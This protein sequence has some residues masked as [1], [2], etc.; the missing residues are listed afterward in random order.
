MPNCVRRPERSCGWK[1]PP[2]NRRTAT[3]RPSSPGQREGRPGFRLHMVHRN[4][5]KRSWTAYRARKKPSRPQGAWWQGYGPHPGSAGVPSA[6]MFS[7]GARSSSISVCLL[8]RGRTVRKRYHSLLLY[9]PQLLG[10]EPGQLFHGQA[11]RKGLKTLSAGLR[12]VTR[13]NVTRDTPVTRAASVMVSWAIGRPQYGREVGS[14][15]LARCARRRAGVTDPHLATPG[16]GLQAGCWRI[17]ADLAEMAGK[18]RLRAWALRSW[19][20]GRRGDTPPARELST[21]RVSYRL[22]HAVSSSTPPGRSRPWG[23][24]GP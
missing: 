3:D 24:C 14:G 1:T 21:H 2:H 7:R 6:Y 15:P 18:G 16:G 4:G 10:S 11:P 13:C 8:D 19:Q 5:A 12:Y 22:R 9:P 23:A 17:E 20:Q